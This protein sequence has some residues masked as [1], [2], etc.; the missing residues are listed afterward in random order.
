MRPNTERSES[1]LTAKLNVNTTKNTTLTFGGNYNST[2]GNR[3]DFDHSL[4]DFESY[5]LETSRIWGRIWTFYSAF[6]E[7]GRG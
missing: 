1:S 3:Y 4:L 7:C 6:S 5:P 2:S